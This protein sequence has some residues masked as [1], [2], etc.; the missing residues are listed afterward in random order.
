MARNYFVLFSKGRKPAHAPPVVQ[1]TSPA[2][3]VARKKVKTSTGSRNLRASVR[4]LALSCS[5]FKHQAVEV[6]AAGVSPFEPP[7]GAAAA[8]SPLSPV[9][10]WEALQVKNRLNPE[11]KVGISLGTQC[12]QTN[13]S[14]GIQC[15]SPDPFFVD[16]CVPKTTPPFAHFAPFAG[17]QDPTFD[18]PV[19]EGQRGR[20]ADLGNASLKRGQIFVQ[21]AQV[22]RQPRDGHCL[23]HS[24]IHG[25]GHTLSILDLRKEL[26]E[27]VLKNPNLMAHGHPLSTWIMWECHCR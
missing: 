9:S 27:F 14:V 22:I 8:A 4:N 19:R 6:D 1:T 2:S 10:S 13:V 16:L 12:N 21:G 20:A 3:N 7:L 5:L 23:F 18:L 11:K 24:L 26:S 15:N 25:L 17:R